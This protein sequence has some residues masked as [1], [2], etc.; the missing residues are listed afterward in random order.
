MRAKLQSV[1]KLCKIDPSALHVLTPLLAYLVQEFLPDGTVR[2][3]LSAA[4]ST[5]CQ[6]CAH[7]DCGDHGLCQSLG[8]R[9]FCECQDGWSG[10]ACEAAPGPCFGQCGQGVCL[11]S[12]SGTADCICLPDTTTDTCKVSVAAVSCD[13]SLALFFGKSCSRKS[14]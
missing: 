3:S 7:L 10:P 9:A 4:G 12:E 11:E 5:E 14:S 8:P 2:I 1:S 13:R 6:T